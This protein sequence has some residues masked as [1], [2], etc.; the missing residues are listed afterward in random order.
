M[1]IF[2]YLR[3]YFERNSLFYSRDILNIY[4]GY[5]ERSSFIRVIF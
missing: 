2:K 4:V 3:Q 5:F 1:Q